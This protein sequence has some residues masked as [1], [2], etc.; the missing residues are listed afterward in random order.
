MLNRSVPINLFEEFGED[1]FQTLCWFGANMPRCITFVQYRHGIVYATF[2][3]PITT[4]MSILAETLLEARQQQIS[5]IGCTSL[6]AE[7]PVVQ[8]VEVTSNPLDL[9]CKNYHK[10][11]FRRWCLPSSS[12]F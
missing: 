1:Y 7:A 4:H 2:R 8:V 9:K 10:K 12:P 5:D 3:C 6:H 11:C